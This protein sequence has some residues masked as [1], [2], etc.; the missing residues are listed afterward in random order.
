MNK[1][2]MQ[3]SLPPLPVGLGRCVQVSQVHRSVKL[4]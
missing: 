1:T 3:R 4:S 2:V